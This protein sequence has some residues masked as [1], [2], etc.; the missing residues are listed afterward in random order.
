ML[1]NIQK[2][3]QKVAMLDPLLSE[4]ESKRF[5]VTVY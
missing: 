4:L 3:T 2:K 1:Y 5:K